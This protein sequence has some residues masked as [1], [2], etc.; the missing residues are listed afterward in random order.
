MVAFPIWVNRRSPQGYSVTT[1]A[2]LFWELRHS[3]L[4]RKQRIVMIQIERL[5]LDIVAKDQN[6]AGLQ[7][8]LQNLNE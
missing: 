1:D 5:A 3:R 2:Y 6:Q 4:N 8:L 7:V